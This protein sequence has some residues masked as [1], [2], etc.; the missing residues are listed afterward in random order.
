MKNINTLITITT[1]LEG[2][3]IHMKGIS[4]DK[5]YCTLFG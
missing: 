2:Q 3:G 5:V 4:N 1:F